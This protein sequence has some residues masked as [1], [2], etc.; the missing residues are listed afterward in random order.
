M[1]RTHKLNGKK[2]KL[3]HQR[4]YHQITEEERKKANKMIK[5]LKRDMETQNKGSPPTTQQQKTER[6]QKR[7]FCSSKAP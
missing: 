2:V 5:G 1:G 7:N 6:E 4:K 3:R